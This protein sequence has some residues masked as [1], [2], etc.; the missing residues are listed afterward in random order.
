MKLYNFIKKR[1]WFNNS[2]LVQLLGLC[3]VLAMTT[4]VV[5]AIGLGISTTFILTITNTIISIF[6]Y[7]VLHAVGQTKA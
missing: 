3:P 1:L 7:F 5:N 2:S 6:K 4:N